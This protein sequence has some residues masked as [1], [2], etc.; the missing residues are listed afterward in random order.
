MTTTATRLAQVDQRATV[1]PILA[2]ALVSELRSAVS[3]LKVYGDDPKKYDLSATFD[4]LFRVAMFTGYWS[5]SQYLQ[6]VSRVCAL[7][8][9]EGEEKVGRAEYLSRIDT[10]T[11][12]VKALGLYLT[13]VA[14]GVN[15]NNST[16]NECFRNLVYKAS[17]EFLELSPEEAES[18]FFMCVPLS[19][20]VEA[21]WTPHASASREAL[22]A[23]LKRALAGDIDYEGLEHANPYPSLSG[24]FLGLS[25]QQELMLRESWR[26]TIVSELEQL[27]EEIERGEVINQPFPSPIIMSQLLW[28]CSTNLSNDEANNSFRRR[29]ALLSHEVI[30]RS[31]GVVSMHGLAKS[32]A[33]SLQEISD[34]YIQASLM[35]NT[36]QLDAISRALVKE[37]KRLGLDSFDQLSIAF[38]SA[39]SEIVASENHDTEVCAQV[40]NGKK[41]AVPPEHVFDAW[42][43]GAQV[44]SLIKQSVETW[45]KAYDQEDLLQI[46]TRINTGGEIGSSESMQ[47]QA[48]DQAVQRVV[49][50]L[51]KEFSSL[52]ASIEN[53]LRMA[54]GQNLDESKAIRAAEVIGQPSAALF[55]QAGGVMHILRMPN[56]SR[57]AG[58][59]L[60][61]IIKEETWRDNTLRL[62]MFEH[63]ARYTVFLGRLRPGALQDLEA[64]E[65]GL[66]SFGGVQPN[67]DAVDVV[68]FD[69]DVEVLE[70]FGEDDQAKGA[71]NLIDFEPVAAMAVEPSGESP[72]AQAEDS[73]SANSAH[74]RPEAAIVAPTGLESP[75]MAEPSRAESTEAVEVAQVEPETVTASTGE[76]VIESGVLGADLMLDF[77][78]DAQSGEDQDV[79]SVRSGEA[80][81]PVIPQ[82][83]AEEQVDLAERGEAAEQVEH[84]GDAKV[85]PST[86]LASIERSL[87]DPEIDGSRL[88]DNS[89]AVG[90]VVDQADVTAEQHELSDSSAL[91]ETPE[92]DGFAAF[93]KPADKAPEQL[94]AELEATFAQAADE[95]ID[96]DEELA[97]VMAEESMRCHETLETA[98]SALAAADLSDDQDEEVADLVGSIKRDVHT[99]KGVARSSGLL[100]VGS[101][102]HAVE[103][104]FEVLG[105][106]QRRF[107][108]AAGACRQVINRMV[109]VLQDYLE[110]ARSSGKSLTETSTA[111]HE[112]G[113][114]EA[115][116][117]PAELS[118]VAESGGSLPDIDPVARALSLGATAA[119]E[120]RVQDELDLQAAQAEV[121]SQ[122]I[123]A[124]TQRPA[125]DGERGESVAIPQRGTRDATKPRRDSTVRL[126][127]AVVEQVGTATGGVLAAERRL[128]ESL[129]RARKVARGLEGNIKRM[130]ASIRDIEIMA[131]ARVAAS[132]VAGAGSSDFDPLE[133]DRYTALQEIVRS[134]TETHRDVLAD[135]AALHAELAE[136]GR[137]EADLSLVSDDLQRESSGMM[138]IPLA[139]QSVR[140]GSV[141]SRAAADCGKTVDL[142][143]E[144]DCR[145]PSAAMDKLNSVFDH[146]LRNAVAHG[147]EANRA[148][149]GKPVSGRITIS[150]SRQSAEVAGMVAISV[151]DDGAGVNTERVL[152]LAQQRG[153]AQPG[154][155]YSQQDIHEFIF[156]HGFST[157]ES[158]NQTSGRGV[159]LD[160]VRDMVARV[161]GVITM[162]STPG[163]GTEFIISL[164]TDAATMAVLPVQQ[165]ATSL[166]IPVSLIREVLPLG[167]S[168]SSER[169]KSTANGF[170]LDGKVLDITTLA[171]KVPDEFSA[172]APEL[173]GGFL[174]VMREGNGTRAVHVQGVKGQY[175]ATVAAL[176]PYV[177]S[178]AGLVAG[179]IGQ[180]GR[181]GLIVNP[182]RLADVSAAAAAQSHAEKRQPCLMVVDD[183]PSMRMVTERAVRRH[184]FSTVSC[185]DGLDALRRIAAGV[186]IDGFLVD[187][188]MPGMDGFG[189]IAELR[190][191]PE[192]K[193]SPIVVITSRSA[194]KHRD[195]AMELGAEEYLTKPYSDED[196]ER[197]LDRHFSKVAEKA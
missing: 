98:F 111:A 52:K 91:V 187:L 57:Y 135:I 196:F 129:G 120:D 154:R 165:G 163:I 95:P 6:G 60:A 132:S 162:E 188:E 153:L 39:V 24:F 149:A 118:Q 86:G 191:M 164:P 110:A 30:K 50:E 83:Q 65:V 12:A 186:K 157:A 108:A 175:R 71:D 32:F 99:L 142:V 2:G 75:L 158:V 20:E 3:I 119:L 1:L 146:L 73:S 136:V 151:R 144:K 100:R 105:F 13:D 42:I 72:A 128:R 51:L 85:P 147:I 44:L 170:E 82:P 103:D 97:T 101:V 113:D 87:A 184:G 167:V 89:V 88:A 124:E 40:G 104:E 67:D 168:M 137:D 190:R 46:A 131:A 161:G 79:T 176:G 18:A 179:T 70:M 192:H 37:S 102:L 122:Q 26:A 81:Q 27:L 140:L 150:M 48:R 148:A 138:L 134:L 169:L 19:L 194:Q 34:G 80:G 96:L 182:L 64:E 173:R 47:I 58:Q 45:H 106:D 178:V 43:K 76:A 197:I 15:A 126:P 36:S 159:G 172:E 59:I 143:I 130:S 189:L 54:E 28:S 68:V 49:T 139:V 25:S 7:I 62:A 166:L 115:L 14:K 107:A 112:A 38:E 63:I 125:L 21:T 56:A 78:L 22:V 90:A 117:A 16:L 94:I 145:V 156:A 171:S 23:Q 121:E 53:A 160:A 84:A 33:R 180:G 193:L 29:Y 195:R 93:V 92:E 181:V 66:E 11:Q 116:S 8:E 77:L 74:S 141:V 127:M 35:R 31:D 10:V 61:E 4:R 133:L 152:K 183:S 174:I 185:Q 55:K 155:A 69:L 17:P 9:S 109:G 41:A 123:A 114:T 5:I 177:R